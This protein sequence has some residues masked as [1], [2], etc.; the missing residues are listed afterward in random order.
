MKSCSFLHAHFIGTIKVV[1]H[2][3]LFLNKLNVVK[4]P[5]IEESCVGTYWICLGN[6]NVHYQHLYL[7]G[8]IPL[9]TK[10]SL[11]Q[12]IWNTIFK[13]TLSINPVLCIFSPNSIVNCLFANLVVEWSNT[14]FRKAYLDQYVYIVHLSH[15]RAANALTS[16]AQTY[17]LAR[18]FAARLPK[19]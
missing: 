5:F 6:S 3:F 4:I 9:C 15:I 17:C 18:T 2:L 19:I 8:T 1:D 10:N 16:L 14:L 11:L 7:Y 13:F 12:K